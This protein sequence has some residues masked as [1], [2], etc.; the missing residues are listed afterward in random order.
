MVFLHSW[1]IFIY[2]VPPNSISKLVI[3]P[4]LG[5]EFNI[6]DSFQNVFNGWFIIDYDWIDDLLFIYDEIPQ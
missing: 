1:L 3:S 2:G 6:M 5:F 4:K